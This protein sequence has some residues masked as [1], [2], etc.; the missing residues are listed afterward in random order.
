[1]RRFAPEYSAAKTKLDKSVILTKIV[2][3]VKSQ[4][5]GT[6]RFV[7]KSKDGR[8]VE[9]NDDEARE[10]TGHS[11]RDALIEI[12]AERER[13]QLETEEQLVPNSRAETQKR[14]SRGSWN[15]C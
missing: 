8:W 11:M 9:I 10:K 13:K 7:K 15:L 1:V 5:V 12:E 6:V 2:D 4:N 14:R 3:A